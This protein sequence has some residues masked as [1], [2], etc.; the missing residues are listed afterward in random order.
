MIKRK[1]ITGV[2]QNYSLGRVY[3]PLNIRGCEIGSVAAGSPNRT[4]AS[5]KKPIHI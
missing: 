5:D 3:L 4:S 2:G 1:Y